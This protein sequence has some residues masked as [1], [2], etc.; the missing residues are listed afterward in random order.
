MEDR[1][2]VRK[3]LVSSGSVDVSGSVTASYFVGDGSFL[4]N[5]SGSFIGVNI[6]TYEFTANG[7][8]TSF[9][10]TKTYD[11]R[12]L[13][14]TVDGLTFN[15]DEDYTISSTNL[16]FTTAP[17]SQS[18]ILVRAFVNVAD[19]ATGTFTGSFLGTASYALA[20]PGGGGDVEW[21]DVLNKPSGLV[22][23]S[24]QVDYTLIQNVPSGI[25]SSSGQV[26][27]LLPTGTVSSSAQI[28]YAQVSGVPAGI[29]SSSGQ[30]TSLL[31]A[32]VVS[33]S[34]QATTWTVATSSIAITGSF[35]KTLTVV[36]PDPTA[37]TVTLWRANCSGSVLTV[38]GLR[39][40]GTGAVV[41][42]RKNSLNLLSSDLSLTTTNWTDG[43]G[44]QNENFVPGDTIYARIESTAG[45]PNE[46]VIQL[47][48]LRYN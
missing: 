22:S 38:R 45:A 46:L 35:S 6:D 12:S 32:G 26:T 3:G 8:D 23:S 18:I 16:N 24:A 11:S 31:P 19:L 10:I 44:L 43:T 28:T 37:I 17:V 1:F 39:T 4:T 33:S 13:I 21:N 34:T 48:M 36:T 27:L 25:V 29:V 42:A 9:N 47:D 15:P 5:V 2:V 20:G 41:N 40:G 7:S 14:V 30:V